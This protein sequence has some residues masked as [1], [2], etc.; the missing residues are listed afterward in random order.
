MQCFRINRKSFFA[1]GLARS[2]SI[3]ISIPTVPRYSGWKTFELH[4]NLYRYTYTF[5]NCKHPGAII[6]AVDTQGKH[7]TSDQA[8]NTL[9]G[10][11]KRKRNDVKQ[12]VGCTFR[13][14]LG[15]N[16]PPKNSKN[17]K[18]ATSVS[19]NRRCWWPSTSPNLGP[20]AIILPWVWTK[21][22]KWFQPGS[23]LYLVRTM[24]HQPAQKLKNLPDRDLREP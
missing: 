4:I 18:I 20:S 15:E 12:V 7:Q 17:T 2:N 11:V 13:K 5:L 19:H 21:E 23:L 22:T 1:T 3:T 16:Y 6:G 10:Y 14:V 8:L 9:P 24:Y